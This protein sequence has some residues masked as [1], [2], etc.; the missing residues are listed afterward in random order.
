MNIIKR[1][2]MSRARAK[3]EAKNNLILL[4]EM[5]IEVY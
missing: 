3:Q 1:H 4:K 2:L 5:G